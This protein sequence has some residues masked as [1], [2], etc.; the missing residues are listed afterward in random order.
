MVCAWANTSDEHIQG[1]N[2]WRQSKRNKPSSEERGTDSQVTST[3]IERLQKQNRLKIILR[4]KEA[5]VR[6]YDTFRKQGIYTCAGEE[7]GDVQQQG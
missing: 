3:Q 5:K 2:F 6:I 1:E 7:G 4:I